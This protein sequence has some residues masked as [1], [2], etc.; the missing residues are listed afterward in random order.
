[1]LLLRREISLPFVQI[2]WAS[3]IS[4]L[5][6]TC[7]FVDEPLVFFLCLWLVTSFPSWGFPVENKSGVIKAIFEGYLSFYMPL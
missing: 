2:Y 3:L 6:Q 4:F 7:F 1:M 5:T